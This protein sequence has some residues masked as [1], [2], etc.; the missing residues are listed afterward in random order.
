[1]PPAES[2]WRRCRYDGKTHHC[3]DTSFLFRRWVRRR[4]R[5]LVIVSSEAAG[6]EEWLY[7]GRTK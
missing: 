6:V 2:P 4:Q 5:S 3:E 1:M 7:L